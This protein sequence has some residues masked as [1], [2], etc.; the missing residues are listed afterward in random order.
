MLQCTHFAD[1]CILAERA[2]ADG[3]PEVVGWVSGY[4]PP[5]EPDAFFVWQVAVGAAARGAGLGRRMIEGLLARPSSAGVRHL[6]TTVTAD[7][8]ASWGLFKGLA[9][10]WDVP[11]GKSAFFEKGAHFDGAHDTEWLARIGPLPTGT[12]P[13]RTEQGEK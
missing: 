4:R 5:S 3:R 7:N 13:D 1:H 2:G 12:E 9:W 8:A 6:L 10:R 11:L